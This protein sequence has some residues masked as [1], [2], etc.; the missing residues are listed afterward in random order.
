MLT[1]INRT[2]FF[3]LFILFFSKVSAQDS[4]I[5]VVADNFRLDPIGNCYFQNKTDII[6]LS[7]LG[8]TNVR[9][10]MKDLGQPSSFDVSNPMRIL[11][12]Y[13]DFA[14][15]RI[16]DNNLVLQSE[17]QLRNLGF[18]QP[19]AIAGTPDQGIWVYDEISGTLSKLNTR[20]GNLS[21]TVDLS[22]LLGRRPNPVQLL[23]NQYW[24][25][26]AEAGELIVFDQFGTKVRSVK[27]ESP[28]RTL[29]LEENNLVFSE[30]NQLISMQLRTGITTREPIRCHPMASNFQIQKNRCWYQIGTSLFS[31]PVTY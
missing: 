9:F 10:S 17:I 31:G 4:L 18:Q 28:T 7:S 15:I 24:I 3:W 26:L 19:R 13:S 14:V 11:V 16:L 6:R 27:L 23:A 20:L 30:D 5:S 29:Q 22:Q 1:S 12:F 25:I 8:Y 2:A 21:T